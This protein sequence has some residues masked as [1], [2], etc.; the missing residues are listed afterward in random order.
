MSHRALP[1]PGHVDA[2]RVGRGSACRRWCIRT[3]HYR[4]S[5][6][7]ADISWAISMSRSGALCLTVAVVVCFHLGEDRHVQ[8]EVRGWQEE[9]LDVAVAVV[10]F[11]VIP[12]QRHALFLRGSEFPQVS[13]LTVKSLSGS[14]C[15]LTALWFTSR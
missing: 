8:L 6:G 11:P 10:V 3:W 15:W 1:P 7:C 9:L 2:G 5:G 14:T 12:D 4:T 13:T